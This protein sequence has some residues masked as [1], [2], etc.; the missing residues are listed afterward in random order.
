MGEI[1]LWHPTYRSFHKSTS[2]LQP[3]NTAWCPNIPLETRWDTIHLYH[4]FFQLICCNNCNNPMLC[5]WLMH[6]CSFSDKIL[7][8]G[9][10]YGTTLWLRQPRRSNMPG[11]HAHFN[12]TIFQKL[13]IAPYE[14]DNI[15]VY[16]VMATKFTKRAFSVM[17]VCKNEYFLYMIYCW[18]SR[19]SLHM[20]QFLL[21]CA[22][23][24]R[25]PRFVM[26][27]SFYKMTE[28]Q[29]VKKWNW[30]NFS[31]QKQISSK[32]RKFSYF[33]SHFVHSFS[34]PIVT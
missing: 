13:I 16:T 32:R 5:C 15:R 6:K 34:L 2:R 20:T 11:R 25:I 19:I 10:A 9:S 22:C 1:L 12:A 27:S 30:Q 18:I 29:D 26:N 14:V 21:L 28:S 4:V 23:A 3:K 24:M 31:S 7:P 17:T 8:P 33:I